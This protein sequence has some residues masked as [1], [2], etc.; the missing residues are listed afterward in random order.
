MQV[1]LYYRELAVERGLLV[2]VPLYYR[3]LAVESAGST[4][5]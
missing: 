5:L 4:V 2:Q 1:P 3:E